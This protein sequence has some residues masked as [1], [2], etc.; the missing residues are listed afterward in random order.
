M[1]GARV[2]TVDGHY[3]VTE[4]DPTGVVAEDHQVTVGDILS[5]M[6]GCVLHNSGLFLNNLRS[7]YDGQPIPVGVTKALMPDGRIYP[8]LRSLLE[9]YG[10]TNLIADLERSGPGILLVNTAF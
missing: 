1:L 9:Q 6:Y 10:Y 4:V 2:E 3:L 8:R 7:L 5:T